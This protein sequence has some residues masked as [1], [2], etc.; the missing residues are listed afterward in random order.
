MGFLYDNES[1][2]K[3]ADILVY[4]WED[5]KDVCFDVTG[6]SPF[7]SAKTRTFTLGHAISATFTRK[8]TKYLDKCVAHGYD[9]GVLAFSILGELGVDTIAFLK[10]LKNFFASY[11]ANYK[12]GSSLFHRLGIVIQKGV[13]SQLVARLPATNV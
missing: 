1:V 2:L 13:G 5:G 10:R 12:I 8:C 6:A 3:P 11:D 7:M 4:N 9:F